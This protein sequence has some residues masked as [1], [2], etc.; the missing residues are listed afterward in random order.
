VAGLA[1]LV[2]SYGLAFTHYPPNA[3]YGRGTSVHL[4]ATFGM[5][6]VFAAVA[7]M[8]SGVAARLRA[9]RFVPVALLSGYLGLLVGYHGVV[10]RDFVRSWA[11][12]R[13][14]WQDVARLAPDMGE[15]TVLVYEYDPR[16]EPTF[17]ASNSWADAITL[18]ML[19]RFPRE[20]LNPPRLFTTT[21]PDFQKRIDADPANPSTLRWWVPGASWDEHWEPLPVGNLVV[22]ARQPDGSLV[23]R[24][25]TVDLNGRQ[26]ALKAPDTS[27]G[28]LDS[29]FGPGPLHDEVLM[30]LQ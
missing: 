12:Q 23:R 27:A 1:C 2:L 21:V 7:A 8:L 14:F 4:A 30:G 19:Y 6:L 29:R 10:Q 20:W 3:V 26:V 9:P 22:F 17:I 15:N 18:P 16:F 5:A 11:S 24:E 13:A 28:S 25:G